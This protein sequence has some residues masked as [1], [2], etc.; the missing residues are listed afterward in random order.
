M[1]PIKIIDQ[2]LTDYASPKVRRFVHSLVSLA[3]A[4]LGVYL[5]A[6]GDWAKAGA[7]LLALVYT[8]ANRVNTPDPEVEAPATEVSGNPSNGLS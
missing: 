1:N 5:A 4:L 8:E 2:I 3:I 7:A 6:E